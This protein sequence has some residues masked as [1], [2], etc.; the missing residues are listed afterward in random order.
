[1]HRATKF[2]GAGFMRIAITFG[3]VTLMTASTVLA[4]IQTAYPLATKSSP[5]A[6]MYMESMYLPPVTSGPWSPAW[7]PNGKE[8]AFCMDGSIWTVRPEGG[9]AV[10]ITS[11]PNYDCEPSWSAD[12]SELAFT[13]DTG[14]TIEIWVIRADGS[15]PRQITHGKG[16]SV[17][18][19]WLPDGSIVYT[20][21]VDANA[22]SIW[23]V[24]KADHEP[25]TV[26]LD[27]Y[28]NLEASPSSDGKKIVFLSN[29]RG[30]ESPGSFW[31]GRISYGSG[32]IW[33][34][35]L[36]SKQQNN[37][38]EEETLYHTR[39]RWSPDGHKIAYVSIRTGR[40]Q[41]WVMNAA[42]GVPAQLTYLEAEP[43]CPV[44]S[45]NGKRIA[46][47]S[48]ARSTFSLWTMPSVGGN[49]TEVKI[50]SRKY[51]EQTGR[52]RVTIKDEHGNST[53]ARVYLTATDGKSHTPIG[54]FARVSSIT[55]DHYF[56]TDGNFLLDLPVGQATIEAMKGFEYFPKKEQVSITAGQT[57]EVTLN[58]TRL[59]DLSAQGWFSGDTHLHMNY[60]GIL[61]ATPDSLLLEAASEDLNVVNDFPTNFDNRLLDLNYF[62][63]QV[64]L[65]S[66]S[67]RVL[68]FNE[69]YRP[70]FGGHLGLLNLKQFVF[71]VYNGY[72]GT[73]YAADYPSNAKIL[74]EVHA[75]GGVGGYVHPY[76]TSKG[77]DPAIQDYFGAREFPADVALGKVDYYDLMCIWTDE[78]VA[79]DVWYRL[80][81]LGYRIPAAA[82]SDA[83]TNYWR[84]PTI[85][86][87]RVYVHIFN[88][89][90][91]QS[92]IDGLKA[93]RTFVTNG[94][95]LR[96][97]VD[98]KEPGSEVRLAE[99][100]PA[101]VHVEAE[102]VSVIPIETLDLVQDGKVVASIPAVD[103]WHAKISADIPVERSGWLAAR[104]SGPENQHLLL[105]SFVYAHTSPIY[106]KT[107]H[108]VP[109]SPED[110][111]YFVKWMDRILQLI[112]ERKDFD[113]DQEK[114]EVKEVYSKARVI[115]NRMAGEK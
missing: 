1:M 15:E 56:A 82:G 27:D 92:W 28:Q 84:A 52:L 59:Q 99:G 36:T 106:L 80:L 58:L 108:A 88:P 18:P 109:Q 43:F 69:E 89:L 71:P 48:S 44:W 23:R 114:Q 63:G 34:F 57:A 16:I 46:Y 87:V 20:S 40:N 4:Q 112:D 10:Q 94:P 72:P 7:S 49:P 12:G 5:G 24:S 98:G 73:P 103:P 21:N 29:R 113:S 97:S 31:T 111:R 102:A 75:Q 26:I 70:N 101:K 51:R 105:D 39:P 45:P 60:G 100:S 54:S 42:T 14:R 91:Y 110:A 13:R 53:P 8:I 50:L 32:A 76:F 3:A 93:G 64:D 95:L 86:S 67:D 62:T 107:G 78:Y 11:G 104:V 38:L 81:N 33:T 68:Y 66:R 47:V 65:H 25:R 85:G 9:D 6:Q 83:M 37:L 79:A 19:A 61:E 55:N 17:D 30:F 115:F 90:S 41:I 2:P 74:D 35:D 22:L 77:Q 96:I